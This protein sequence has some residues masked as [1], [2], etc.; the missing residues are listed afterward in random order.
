MP[1]EEEWSVAA[2]L[3]DVQGD[4]PHA[5]SAGGVDLVAVRSGAGGALK[6]FE[7]RCPHQGALLGEGEL[8]GGLL[9]CRNHRWKFDVVSGQ[10]VSGRQCLVACPSREEGGDL[11]VDVRALRAETTA[12]ATTR[13]EDLHGPRGIPVL[14][15]AL[16]VEP[17]RLHL[18]LE[19]WHARTPTP[20]AIRLVGRTV[21]VI[22]DPDVIETVLRARPESY[23]RVAMV[24]TVFDEMSLSGVFSAEGDAWRSQRR[25]AMEALSQRHLRGFYPML[26][27]VAGRL[28]RR[29]EK[30]AD[31]GAELDIA[32]ELKR[33]TV[34]VTTQLVFGHDLDTLSRPDDDEEIIQ[35][36]LEVFFPAFQ[37]RLN[38]VIPYWRWFRL[39]QDRRVD[40][41]I[42]AIRAW[43]GKR[44]AASRARL[45]EDPARRDSPGNFIEAMLV[46]RD[47]DGQPFSDD[48]IFGNALTMLLAGEDTT[49]YTLAWAVHH[50]CEEPGAT[51]A[52]R[53]ELENVLGADRI[54]RDLDQASRLPYASAVANESMR[55]RPVAPFQFLQAL[56]D[57]VIDGIQVPEGTSIIA[58]MR[59]AVVDPA[60]FADPAAFRPERWVAELRT[61]AH[62][63]AAHMPF[64]SGPRICPGRSLALLEMRVVL[65]ALY[66]N[67]EVER[68]GDGSQVREVTAF[69]M[70]PEGIRVK[71]RRHAS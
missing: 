21:L 55:L 53:T 68:V 18:Q 23:R 51:R 66:R 29:W 19:E 12:P 32:A 62:E 22:S 33:F 71:L 48:V 27:K 28:V 63:A 49:A 43:I 57:V 24:E 5:L 64:G 25:L 70:M 17:A 39:P 7:G 20:Y 1:G 41:A 8:E 44:V 13:L 30:A 10:R 61:G 16:Q 58:M 65:A 36:H 31:A 42:A 34:D 2:R 47:A 60:R 11:L 67:F 45:A 69:T 46:A 37:R 26:E 9:V 35:E 15:N 38:A 3:A 4:G 50:L 6:V 54:P 14:G 56:H 52:L 40:R 59:P